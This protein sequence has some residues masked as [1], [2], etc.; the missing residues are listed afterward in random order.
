MNLQLQ[1]TTFSSP[2]EG[3]FGIRAEAHGTVFFGEA[4][5]SKPDGATA[6]IFGVTCRVIAVD[7]YGNWIQRNSGRVLEV[8]H[9]ASIEKT[10]HSLDPTLQTTA[11][12]RQA[13]EGAFRSLFEE[14]AVEQG[15]RT[16]LAGLPL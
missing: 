12:M 6:S 16:M 8:S 5:Y 3:Y 2:T 4:Q 7:A 10:A 15:N 14:L 11:L 13:L 1:A 9:T